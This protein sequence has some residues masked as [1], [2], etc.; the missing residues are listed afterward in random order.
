MVCGTCFAKEMLRDD[1]LTNPTPRVKFKR[2]WNLQKKFVAPNG[3]V[4]S[5]GELVKKGK[6]NDRNTT[7]TSKKN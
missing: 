3:D 6:A 1:P 4:Y 2:G 7:K 5:H